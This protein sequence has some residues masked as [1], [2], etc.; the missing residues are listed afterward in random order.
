LTIERNDEKLEHA[1]ARCCSGLQSTSNQGKEVDEEADE[2]ES[3][4][5]RQIDE[6]EAL[7]QLPKAWSIAR[8]YDEFHVF[9]RRLRSHFGSNSQPFALLPDRKMMCQRTKPF[10]ESHR[11]HFEAFLQVSSHIFKI[12][13]TFLL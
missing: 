13:K 9:D 3:E 11:K 8:S 1:T 2:E 10:L 7:S 12:Q 5:E 4:L 6:F